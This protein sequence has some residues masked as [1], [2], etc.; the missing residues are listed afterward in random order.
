VVVLQY[1]IKNT[2]EDQILSNV[3]IKIKSL[4]SQQGL[5]VK[6]MV[7]LHEEDQIKFD[8]HRCAYVILDSSQTSAGYPDL[9][10]AQKLLFKITEIDTDS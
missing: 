8:Q 3:Q 10:V 6:G 9:K 4:S 5:K 7:P 2:L 1:E